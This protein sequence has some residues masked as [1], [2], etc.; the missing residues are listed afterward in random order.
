M[1]KTKPNLTGKWSIQSMSMWDETYIN[2]ETPG[3]FHFGNNNLGAFHF[4]YVQGE[5]DYRL[6]VRDGKPAVEF[7]WTGFDRGGGD[8][9]SGRGWMVLDGDE[10]AG[11]LFFHCGDE[12]EIVLKRAAE[13]R[14]QRKG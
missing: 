5:V 4:A 13:T 8:E 11:M 1:A 2:E 14:K 7:S 3:Y 10:L 6:S 12:S 9:C